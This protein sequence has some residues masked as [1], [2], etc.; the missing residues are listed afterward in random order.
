MTTSETLTCQEWYR[1]RRGED[2]IAWGRTHSDPALANVLFSHRSYQ[3][4]AF[5]ETE[6]QQEVR[7]ALVRISSLPP[8]KQGAP[9]ENGGG[10]RLVRVGQL[11]I[12]LRPGMA[13]ERVEVSTIRGG[14]VL[15]PENV[16]PA[17]PR[18]SSRTSRRPAPGPAR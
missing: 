3:E 11:R 1:V 14:K 12:V 10:R 13:G 5:L 7:D 8:G 4:L 17:T 15:D 6:Q 18:P 9:L 16:G 2:E